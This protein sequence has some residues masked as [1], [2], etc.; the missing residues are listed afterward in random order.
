MDSDF[1]VWITAFFKL[2][3]ELQYENLDRELNDPYSFKIIFYLP[4]SK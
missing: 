2:P 1:D 4:I 3:L